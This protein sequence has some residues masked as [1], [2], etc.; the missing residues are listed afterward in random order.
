MVYLFWSSILMFTGISP[1]VV[2][3]VSLAWG[4]VPA[5]YQNREKKKPVFIAAPLSHFLKRAH[6]YRHSP[7]STRIGWLPFWDR[8]LP[9]VISGSG[10]W[11]LPTLVS[12]LR[13]Y[14]YICSV[15]LSVL[16]QIKFNYTESSSFRVSSLTASVHFLINS[17]LPSWIHLFLFSTL[18]TWSI[19]SS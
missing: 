9:H 11:A 7:L 8:F 6:L 15:T 1:G 14:V 5:W 12:S 3:E 17:P 16:L 2:S 10:S 13:I 4:I 19:L 18:F